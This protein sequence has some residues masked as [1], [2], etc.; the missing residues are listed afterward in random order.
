MSHTTTANTEA[1]TDH[2]IFM[3]NLTNKELSMMTAKKNGFVISIRALDPDIKGK[4]LK[5][6]IAE[7]FRPIFFGDE[8]REI[9]SV[10]VELRK[11]F[12]HEWQ[13][14]STE[15]FEEDNTNYGTWSV[16]GRQI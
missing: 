1:S 4:N 13:Y 7:M 2:T 3:K 12:G 9:P 10:L 8:I 5:N 6:T 15:L 11:I 16:R 14:S